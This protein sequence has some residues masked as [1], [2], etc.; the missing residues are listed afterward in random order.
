[1]HS[2]SVPRIRPNRILL[3]IL[4]VILS[5]PTSAQDSLSIARHGGET[6]MQVGDFA[7]TGVVLASTDLRTWTPWHAFTKPQGPMQ[8]GLA[9]TD[10]RRFFRIQR[11]SFAVPT[12]FVWIPSGVFWMGS[13]DTELH[14]QADEGLH[15][16]RIHR[17]FWMSMFEVTAREF[18]GVM[19]FNPSLLATN[20]DLNQPVD[21]AS[22]AEAVEFCEKITA[23]DVA[24]NKIPPGTAYRL[25]TEAEW[26]YACRA[27]TSTRYYFGEDQGYETLR[28]LGWYADSSLGKT[29]SVGTLPPNPW[30]LYDM[31]G[32][33]FEWCIDFYGAYPGGQSRSTEKAHAYRGGSYYC[34]NWVLRSAERHPGSDVR[35]SLI[36]FR[37]VLAGDADTVNVPPEVAALVPCLTWNSDQ[38]EVTLTATT[39]TEG[40]NIRYVMNG[41]TPNPIFGSTSGISTREPTV[42]KARAYRTNWLASPLLTITINQALPPV[43]NSQEDQV[44]LVGQTPYGWEEYRVGGGAWHRYTGPVPITGSG[45]LQARG[46]HAEMLTSAVMERALPQ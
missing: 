28:N 17:G 40:V 29:H 22:W 36:G 13:P 3:A 32:N 25:P 26:E 19:G 15:R 30:G 23:R 34:P 4:A 41:Y 1:M 31:I 39:T 37:A 35:S 11:R 42:L 7:G 44:I 2:D 6:L 20:L 45:S 5:I 16:V 12:H 33:V 8:L 24:L 27:G 9:D 21:N 14:H 18:R 38:T 43:I 10:D 46:R